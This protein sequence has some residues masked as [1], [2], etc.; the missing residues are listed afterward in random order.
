MSRMSGTTENVVSSITKARRSMQ[1]FF[2]ENTIAE[3]ELYKMWI[4]L[5]RGDI[6][7]EREGRIRA[8]AKIEELR[9]YCKNEAAKD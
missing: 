1:R 8:E 9:K 4:T 7:R 6:E 3:E 2:P 5:L